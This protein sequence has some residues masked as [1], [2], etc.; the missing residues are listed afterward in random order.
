MLA[1]AGGIALLLGIVGI[2]GVSACAVAQRTREVGVRMALGAQATEVRRMFLRSAGVLAGIGVVVGG[3]GAVVLTRLMRALLF[4]TSPLDP[5][6]FALVPVVLM[7][8]A[9]L[10]G[11]LPARRASAVDPIDALRAD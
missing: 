9:L 11:Y 5:V 3:G 7:G 8:S 2:Y 4:E 10:A 6:T 1:I